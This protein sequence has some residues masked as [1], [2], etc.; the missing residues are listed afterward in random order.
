MFEIKDSN[1]YIYLIVSLQAKEQHL[2]IDI[3]FLCN[4]LKVCVCVCVV[5]VCVC[6]CGVCVCVGVCLYLN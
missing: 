6:G 5:G 1:S 4:H 2:K 3:A